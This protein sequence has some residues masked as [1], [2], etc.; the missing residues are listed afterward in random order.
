MA[1]YRVGHT[2]ELGIVVIVLIGVVPGWKMGSHHYKMKLLVG[3]L[4]DTPEFWEY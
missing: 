3:Y 2:T 1:R 4:P